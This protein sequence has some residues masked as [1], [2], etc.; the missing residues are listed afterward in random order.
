MTRLLIAL[1]LCAALVQGQDKECVTKI[2][3][4]YSACDSVERQES[5]RAGSPLDTN[6]GLLITGSLYRLFNSTTFNGGGGKSLT[7]TYT[8][9]SLLVSG[10]LDPNE[11]AK[12][13]LRFIGVRYIFILD[14]LRNEIEVLQQEAI[15]R[16]TNK[17]LYTFYDTETMTPKEIKPLTLDFLVVLM[18]QYEAECRA[19]SFQVADYPK[20][21]GPTTLAIYY[22]RWEHMEPTLKGFR[23]FIRRKVGK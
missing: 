16:D 10:G 1:T 22:F 14:S 23:D 12:T 21:I 19:D 9:D 2:V 7:I 18:D 6:T 17:V 11:A 15:C 3:S 8:K 13:F 5:Q 4:H 20:G